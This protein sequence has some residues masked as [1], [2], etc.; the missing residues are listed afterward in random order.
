MRSA[1]AAPVPEP[2]RPRRDGDLGSLLPHVA[3]LL[4]VL[5]VLLIAR[6]FLSGLTAAPAPADE[7]DDPAAPPRRVLG[8]LGLGQQPQRDPQG[9][10][11]LGHHPGQLAAPDHGDGRGGLIGHGTTLSSGLPARGPRA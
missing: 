10:G 5:A 11:R 7:Y 8:L 4:A 1:D 3:L 9:G 2:S 6:S